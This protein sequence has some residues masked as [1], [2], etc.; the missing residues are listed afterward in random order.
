MPLWISN[1]LTDCCNAV[2]I[3]CENA[4]HSQDL[5]TKYAQCKFLEIMAD[6]QASEHQIHRYGLYHEP[7]NCHYIVKQV[8]QKGNDS[9]PASLMKIETKN[10]QSYRSNNINFGIQGHVAPISAVWFC[11]NSNLI[12]I[13]M[14][15]LFTCKYEDLIKNGRKKWKE[16]FAISFKGT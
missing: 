16:C 10:K 11:W 14:P 9:S 1:S 13:F 4:H 7:W 3:L 15:F 12:M 6:I 2:I 5:S 8:A